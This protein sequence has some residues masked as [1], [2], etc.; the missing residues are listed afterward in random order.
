[1]REF[2]FACYGKWK[3]SQGLAE[4]YTIPWQ[5]NER[6]GRSEDPAEKNVPAAVRNARERSLSVRGARIFNLLPPHLRNE[7]CGDY[8]LF[9]NHLDIFLSGI[10]DEPTVQGLSRPTASNSLIDQIPAALQG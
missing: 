1:M 2:K 5:W 6:R 9:K 3:I 10:P 4:G 8:E 7:D